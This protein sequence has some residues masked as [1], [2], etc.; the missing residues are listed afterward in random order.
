MLT[1]ILIFIAILTNIVTL[2]LVYFLFKKSTES[3][4]TI[5][6]NAA[7]LEN[8]EKQIESL[9]NRFKESLENIISKDSLMIE[10]TSSNIIKYYQDTVNSLTANYNFNSQKLTENLNLELKKRV[11]QLATI[12]AE[13]SEE[14]K[15]VFSSEIQKDLVLIKR[16]LANYSQGKFA[17]VDAKAYQIISETAKNTV[18]K[19]INM[20]DHQEL[21]MQA[22]DEA[23]KDKFFG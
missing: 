14:S 22:L 8:T 2:A 17:Q 11:D 20:V 3:S 9:Q 13:Q 1:N 16:D 21:V 6:T 15:K 5:K 10:N 18:G 7:F 4:N 12:V 19:V 23:K